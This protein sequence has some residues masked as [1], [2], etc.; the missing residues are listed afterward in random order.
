MGRRRWYMGQTSLGKAGCLAGLLALVLLAGA[1]LVLFTDVGR[2]GH[3]VNVRVQ[4]DPL[5]VEEL[6]R[7]SPTGHV[8][9][10]DPAQKAE[11]KGIYADIVQAYSNGQV[12]V[13]RDF[14][15][16]LPEKVEFIGRDDLI[17]VGRLFLDVL[18]V[19]LFEKVNK[20]LAKEPIGEKFHCVGEFEKHVASFLEIVRLYGDI[21]VRR[22]ARGGLFEHLEAYVFLRLK[23]YR[24]GFRA[25]GRPDME[26]AAGRFLAE[27][28]KHIE[29]ENGYTRASVIAGIAWARQRGDELMKEPSRTWEDVSQSVVRGR[30]HMLTLFGYTPKWLD[31][32][33]NIPRHAIPNAKPP[34]KGDAVNSIRTPLY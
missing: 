20:I 13:L 25:E 28:I 15:R 9:A 17:E 18:H 29:S 26:Q 12:E 30:L 5:D 2:H 19:E 1:F 27:W 33:S 4:P 22:R 16:G 14:R 7:L 11:L 21:Q 8:V 3:A 23:S 34:M 31:E 6:R 24:D 10:L 32:F